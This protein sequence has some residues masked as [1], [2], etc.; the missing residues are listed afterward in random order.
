MGVIPV[1]VDTSAILAIC[2]G[3][4]HGAWAKQRLNLHRPELLMS[5]I[6]LTESLI[7][8]R[9][10][11]PAEAPALERF[12]FQSGIRFIAPDQSQAQIAAD[13]RHRF[14]LNLGDCFVYALARTEQCGII[15]VDRD[16]RSVDVPV[17]LP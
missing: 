11:R 2:F 6:N 5:T 15:T 7:L 13:A 8:I 3:E 14:P 1:V 4:V 17:L 16:F 10:R 9:D 12:L